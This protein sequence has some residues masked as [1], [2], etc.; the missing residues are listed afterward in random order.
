MPNDNCLAGMACPQCGSDGPFSITG[1]ATF[2]VYDDG[3]DLEYFGLEWDD[4]A[5]CGC[6]CGHDA[7]VTDFTTSTPAPEDGEGENA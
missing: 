4:D 5:Y 2:V 3:T 7:T 1:T 6:N